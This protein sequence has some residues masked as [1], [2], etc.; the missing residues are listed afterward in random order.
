MQL[1]EL[2]SKDSVD[3]LQI[4]KTTV[5]TPTKPIDAD[6]YVKKKNPYGFTSNAEMLNYLKNH[7]SHMIHEHYGYPK[8]GLYLLPSGN[9]KMIFMVYNDIDYPIC[10]NNKEFTESE[11]LNYTFV[12]DRDGYIIYGYKEKKKN[13]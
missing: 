7:Q 11:F 5:K 3:K 12:K 2:I 9:I 1:L 6:I 4:F 13:M 10:Y 8:E